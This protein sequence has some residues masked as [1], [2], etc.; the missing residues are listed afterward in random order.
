MGEELLTLL[1]RHRLRLPAP[2]ALLL[3]AIIMMEGIGVQIDPQLD[4]FGIARPYAMRALAQLNSPDAQLRRAL[5]ELEE[6]RGIVSALPGQMST[7]VQ[8]LNEGEIR[9]QTREIEMRR[10]AAALSQAGARI[11]LGLI[12]LAATLGLAG[13]AIAAAIGGWEGW[14]VIILAAG[15]LIAL[16]S[17]GAT[18][19][20]SIARGS[21]GSS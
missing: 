21:G 10:L 11:A 18:L 3:K 17:A 8:R 5:R 7:L 16:I 13:L 9:I 19:F 2:L 4:V 20:I 6:M 15:A 1:Q 14:P 12:V